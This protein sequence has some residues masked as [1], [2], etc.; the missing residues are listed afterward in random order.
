[1]T[2]RPA[3]TVFGPPLS[4]RAPSLLYFTLA[5]CVAAGVLFGYLSEPGTALHRYVVELDS[6]RL[7]GS[8]TFACILMLSALSSVV[9]ASMR[10]VRIRADGIEYREVIAL[11]LPRIRRYKW[12]QIVRILLDQQSVSVELWDGRRAILPDVLDRRGLCAA[13]EKVAHARAIPVQGGLGLDELP[14]S[15]DFES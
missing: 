4:V 3:E 5:T 15:G 11:L 13:L 6:G 2:Y 8:R 1:M 10:G 9:R 7:I 14:E 12:P